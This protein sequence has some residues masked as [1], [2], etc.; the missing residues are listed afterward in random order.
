MRFNSL[1][2]RH[3]QKPVFRCGVVWPH[4]LTGLRPNYVQI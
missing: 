3:R 1:A 4:G 2:S